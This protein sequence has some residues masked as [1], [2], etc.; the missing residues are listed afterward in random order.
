MAV[1][2]VKRAPRRAWRARRKEVS[3]LR[4]SRRVMDFFNTYSGEIK[5]VLSYPFAKAR[6]QAPA[7]A[8]PLLLEFPPIAEGLLSPYLSCGQSSVK[9]CTPQSFLLRQTLAQ[10]NR[11]A[12]DESIARAG[13]VHG[14]D[15]ECGNELHPVR[16]R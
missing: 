15:L 3:I 10:K 4:F 8:P 11:E 2:V 9:I 12:A 16:S 13:G 7:A 6:L 5:K 1:A 14:L